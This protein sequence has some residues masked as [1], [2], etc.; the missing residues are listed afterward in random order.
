MPAGRRCEARVARVASPS[1]SSV[2]RLE[3]VSVPSSL[4]R[5]QSVIEVATAAW[6]VIPMVRFFA[7]ESA[8]CPVKFKV[9]CLHRRCRGRT[10]PR[11]ESARAA[12]SFELH[13]DP[14]LHELDGAAHRLLLVGTLSGD[15]LRLCAAE[16][17]HGPSK[18]RGKNR[19]ET[20][21]TALSSRVGVSAW[22]ARNLAFQLSP[23][24]TPQSGRHRAD[25]RADA[26]RLEPL[27]AEIAAGGIG[28]VCPCG[29]CG[30][31]PA[32]RPSDQNDHAKPT[33]PGQHSPAVQHAAPSWHNAQCRP[34]LCVAQG[35]TEL[36]YCRNASKSF[37]APE[38]CPLTG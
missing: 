21:T 30:I 29:R 18:S 24:R 8:I 31:A 11:Y 22:N 4:S 12:Q 38:T 10:V 3:S 6:S 32:S 5:P 33:R 25:G 14:V 23:A 35:R 1:S 9:Q 13:R 37:E 28:V 36:A 27:L 34:R 26:G 19:S 7:G 17:L 20:G 15:H 2:G 16:P